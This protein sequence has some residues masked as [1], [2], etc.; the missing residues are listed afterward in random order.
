[1]IQGSGLWY[2]APSISSHEIESS[3]YHQQSFSM[4]VRRA[5]L[6]PRA[7]EMILVSLDG[8]H[9][10]Y[11][12]ICRRGRRSATGDLT[13]QVTHL[14]SITGIPFSEMRESLPRSVVRNFKPEEE[15]THRVP[16]R[17]WEEVLALLQA[18]PKIAGAFAPI[19]ALISDSMRA[20]PRRQ[21]DLEIF[22]RDAIGS[23]I[24]TWRGQGLRKRVLRSASVATEDTAPYFITRL[25]NAPTREDLQINH[26]SFHF[27]GMESIRTNVIGSVTFTSGRNR[28]TIINCNRQPLEQTLGVDLIYYSHVYDAFV[29]VQYKRMTK[30]R[31][32]AA[33]RTADD[34]FSGEDSSLGYRPNLDKD[35]AKEM[36]QMRKATH[37]LQKVSTGGTKP[38]SAF[39]LDERPFYLKLCPERSFRA[40]DEELVKGMYIP[41]DLWSQLITSEGVKGT[42]GSARITWENCKRRFSNTEFTSLLS[43]G[44]IGSACG[45]S[46]YL[47]ELV[48]EVLST[49]KM[50][51]LAGT[52]G[53]DDESGYR[54]DSWG[55][56][57]DE[58]DVFGSY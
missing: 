36:Q 24:Q 10:S 7:I 45:Q 21:R 56:F 53:T 42:R 16:P 13:L 5:V 22:E 1:M 3:V 49:G 14:T 12:G 50:V 23:A 25:Q 44:W 11:T 55:R 43:N 51:I 2:I 29:M 4:N 34:A 57:T 6:K 54:R 47:A 33:A 15:G 26:D 41:F 48:N 58:D 38:L 8:N 30:E 37:A 9:F 46:T 52:S 20:A 32:S 35:L 40:I 19:E 28:L 18:D 27:P 39:R 17:L 31:P